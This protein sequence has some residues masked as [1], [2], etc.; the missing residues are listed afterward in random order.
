MDTTLRPDADTL[1][2]YGTLLRRRVLI[3]AALSFLTLI[4]FLADV[5]LGPSGLSLGETIQGLLF[6]DEVKRS[7]TVILYQVRLPAAVMAVLVGVGLSLA[8]A[9]M[10]TLMNNAMASPFTLGVSSAAS[11]G[12]AFAIVLG[13]SIPGIPQGWIVAFNAF[14][15][16]F[17]SMALLQLLVRL[18]GAGAETLVLFGI[19][20][21]FTFNALVSLLQ[22]VASQET[23]QRLVFWTLGSLTRA[24]WESITIL[25]AVILVITPLSFRAAWGLTALRL[26]EDRARSFGVDVGRLRIASLLRIALLTSASVAFVGIIG[27]IGLV[28]PHIARLL[29]G[30]DHRFFLPVSALMGALVMSLS[31]IASKMI[32]P[33]ILIPVGIVTALVGLPIFF[34]LILKRKERL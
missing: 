12:A 33:G 11:L 18:R 15:F 26:G 24:N 28:G 21:V 14:V 1:A 17:G 32:V 9:E 13:I 23:L 10:Q 27:F 22:F 2:E 31:S 7:V 19:A 25:G 30:E 8:G 16:A 20:L 34:A 6:P 29:V 3:V 5:A 4:A